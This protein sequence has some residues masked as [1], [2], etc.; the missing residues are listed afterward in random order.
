MDVHL[1]PG[2]GEVHDAADEVL[3]FWFS[4]LTPEQW[5]AK[6]A[7]VDRQC[8]ERFATMRDDVLASDALGWR[9]EPETMLAAI[10]LLDQISRNA[11]RDSPR[12][13]EADPLAERLSREAI[14]KG[15]VGEFPPDHAQFLLLPLQ[16]AEHADAQRLSIA[17]YE[18]L[19]L[20]EQIGYAREH[21]DVFER[22]GR[23]PG[24]NAALGR[25]S[26]PEE[27][28]YLSQPGAGW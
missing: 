3:D 27:K 15:W 25:E 7:G 4:E 19:G 2:L 12:A 8:A 9:G 22:F 13:F 14:A 6:D 10:I 26:T 1:G 16:H 20:A 11:Y 18:A 21:R 24:R 28:E 23:F 5:F 17:Q